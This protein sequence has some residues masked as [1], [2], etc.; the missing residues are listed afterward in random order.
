MIQILEGMG[1]LLNVAWAY[2]S[3]HWA[4]ILWIYYLIPLVVCFFLVLFFVTDTPICLVTRYKPKKALR[5][6]SHIAKINRL[7]S[8]ELTED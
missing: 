3:R 2:M 8:L 5:K 7:P 4:P 1:G 6:F